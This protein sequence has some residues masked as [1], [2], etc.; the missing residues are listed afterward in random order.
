MVLSTCVT[1]KK[2]D[3]LTNLHELRN[4]ESN[5]YRPIDEEQSRDK[6]LGIFFTGEICKSDMYSGHGE[7]LGGFSPA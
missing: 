1:T 6:I 7:H 3:A 2:C 4:D 5:K